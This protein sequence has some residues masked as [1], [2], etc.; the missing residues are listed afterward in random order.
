MKK[1]FNWKRKGLQKKKPDLSGWK[2]ALQNFWK[3]T[4]NRTMLIAAISCL[5]AAVLFLYLYQGLNERDVDQ[6]AAERWQS[7]EQEFAQISAFLSPEEKWTEDDRKTLLSQIRMSFQENSIENESETGGE[8]GL[9][10]DCYSYETKL[11]LTNGKKTAEAAVTVTGGDFFYFHP[12]IW[13]SG[14]AYSEEDIMQDRIVLDKELAWNLYGSSQVEGMSLKID[15]KTFYVAGVVDRSNDNA[16]K[17]AYGESNRAWLSY[18]ALASGMEEKPAITAYEIVMPNPVSGWAKEILS[19]ALT[20]ENRE[21]VVLENSGRAG[22]LQ[23]FQD[24]RGFAKKTMVTKAVKYPYWENASRIRDCEREICLVLAVLCIV[25]PCGLC[26][27]GIV[28]L[29]RLLGRKLSLLKQK[30]TI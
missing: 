18:D 1:I 23:V 13:L 16:M 3:V 22:F 30:F 27:F 2:E 25:Y 11:T 29:Y 15:D 24:I 12:Q 17:E 21:I 4:R 26:L 6:T 20:P 9:L 19:N 5:L 7:G 28:R 10:K 8:E 14:Y